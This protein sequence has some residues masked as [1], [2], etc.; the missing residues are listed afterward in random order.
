MYKV[1]DTNILLL[2][3]QNLLELGSRGDTIVIPD[4]VVDEIDSKK[5]QLTEIGYQARQFG[6][7]MS[8]A[9]V[10]LVT[11]V[12]TELTGTIDAVEVYCIVRDIPVII[13]SKKKYRTS[14]DIDSSIY[15]DRK[16]IEV[17]TDCATRF[18]KENVVF[19]SN[20]VMCRTRALSEG[21]TVLDYLAVEEKVLEFN[22]IITLDDPEL[23]R[24]IHNRNIVD[25]D[26]SWVPANK[27]Y[28]VHCA[29][30][31]DHKLGII[32]HGKFNVLS[33]S[34]EADLAKQ[35]VSPINSG[36]KFLSMAIQD[37]A[38]DVVVVDAA[39]GSGKTLVAISNAMR[40]MDTKPYNGILYVRNSVQDLEKNEELG[41]LKGDMSDKTGV[42]FTPLEDVL[43]FIASNKL[44]NSKI[45]GKELET[46]I[47]EKIDA[48]I[49]TYHIESSITLGMRGR[50]FSDKIIILDEA[51]SL[52]ASAM[53]K[54]LTRVG[55]NCKVIIIGSQ[56]Q[57]DNSYLTRYT[58]G[59]AI[60]LDA[61][62]K[63]LD[64]PVIMHA[65]QL[66]KTVRS[67][68]TELAEKLFTLNK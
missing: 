49:A 3:A 33:K 59:L 44:S 55:K 18:G 13:I 58:N 48:L 8:E 6:R 19:I 22:K 11:Q 66:P 38:I 14:P 17:A 46:A 34:G 53:Q 29:T 35:N 39:A 37:T 4:T 16:I 42:F 45:K 36:Q 20:D 56:N 67:P 9:K 54:V 5:S 1:I 28:T 23:F 2:D 64:T 10:V 12:D 65:V 24:S 25:I 47:L 32:V 63:E 41:F 7:L 62:T 27:N 68:L 50:T 26:P 30:T 52:S 31:G 60:M 57:I 43:Y 40:L 61:C 21:L 15:N 51:Q